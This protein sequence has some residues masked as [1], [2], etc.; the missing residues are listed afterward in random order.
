MKRE[1]VE[2][3]GNRAPR[4][5]SLLVNGG[6]LHWQTRS[7][8]YVDNASKD[9]YTIHGNVLVVRKNFPSQ[10]SQCGWG[11]ARTRTKTMVK[12]DAIYAKRKTTPWKQ[13]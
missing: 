7:R 5:I 13:K 3:V 8:A 12:L 4:L 10:S 6:M 11:G 1:L 2:N 9:A